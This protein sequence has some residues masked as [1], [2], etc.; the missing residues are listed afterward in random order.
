MLT[1][2]PHMLEYLRRNRSMGAVPLANEVLNRTLEITHPQLY[3]LFM[4]AFPD[5]LFISSRP[6]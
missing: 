6:S 2:D 1:S 4:D 3:K 5:V